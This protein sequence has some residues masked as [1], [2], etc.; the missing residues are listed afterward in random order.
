MIWDKHTKRML[1]LDLIIW[2]FFWFRLKKTNDK[3][4]IPMLGPKEVL[5]L[6]KLVGKNIFIKN[7]FSLLYEDSK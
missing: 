2:L 3:N 4:K 6:L 5:K 1:L 7:K